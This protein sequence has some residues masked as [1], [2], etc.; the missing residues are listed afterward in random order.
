MKITSEWLE[1]QGA[2]DGAILA[3]RQL[4]PGGAEIT[5]EN[6]LKAGEAGLNFYWMATDGV[7]MMD[8]QLEKFY[9]LDVIASQEYADA[10]RS[11]REIFDAVYEAA[12]AKYPYGGEIRHKLIE[13]ARHIYN[14]ALIPVSKA[15]R[16]KLAKAFWE[17]YSGEQR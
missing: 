17:V 4:F 11:L 12:V 8:K 9:E 16:V 2:C 5:E 7:D 3:F 14:N 6:C 13:D 1:E 10:E 15:Y